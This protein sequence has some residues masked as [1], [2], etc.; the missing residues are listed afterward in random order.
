MSVKKVLSVGFVAAVSI[1]LVLPGVSYAWDRDRHDDRRD[2]R[3]YYRYHD[4]P[5]FGL[6]LTFA[7]PRDAFIV[8]VSNSRYYYYDGLYYNRLGNEYMLVPPPVGAVVAV[9]PSD[10]RPVAVN[11]VTY[12]TDNGTYYVY[13]RYGYQVVPPPFTVVTAPVVIASS[14]PVPVVSSASTALPVAAVA[15]DQSFTVNIPDKKGGYTAV[16]IKRS[17]PGFTGPQGEYYAEFPKV[18]QLQ[19]MYAK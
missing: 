16:V 5:S 10:F 14:V 7:P 8:H 12:Y 15:E 4:R 13:T 19:V 18:T 11:G 3:H 17:G 1:M 6:R 9:I 2:D